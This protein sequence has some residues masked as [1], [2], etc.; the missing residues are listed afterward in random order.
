LSKGLYFSDGF[1][2]NRAQT[3]IKR[4][5]IRCVVLLAVNLSQRFD[6]VGIDLTSLFTGSGSANFSR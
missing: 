6:S 3:A 2:K 5:G 1:L 4:C